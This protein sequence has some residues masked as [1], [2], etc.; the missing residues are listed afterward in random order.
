MDAGYMR[1]YLG[2]QI[3][4]ME[5]FVQSYD[6]PGFKPLRKITKRVGKNTYVFDHTLDKGGCR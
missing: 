4:V 6:H 2:N 5:D 1:K 3:T